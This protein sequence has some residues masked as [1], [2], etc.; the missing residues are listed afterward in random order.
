MEDSDKPPAFITEEAYRQKLDF[1][2]MFDRFKHVYPDAVC[3]HAMYDGMFIEK[4]KQDAALEMLSKH[5]PGSEV[6]LELMSPMLP[7]DAR[8]S[9]S[10]FYPNKLPKFLYD[11]DVF[12]GSYLEI[13]GMS[14]CS[15]E[16]YDELKSLPP[17]DKA[18]LKQDFRMEAEK[19]L[20]A[21]WKAA[22]VRVKQDQLAKSWSEYHVAA[23]GEIYLVVPERVKEFMKANCIRPSRECDR[24]GETVLDEKAAEILREQI[25]RKT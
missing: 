1:Q 4:E 23:R 21:E 15:P 6:T 16:L 10:I 8:D 22:F 9:A 11:C 20:G 14:M 19:E 17:N 13:I 18:L 3:T 7:S 25:D 12:P 24:Y 5:F 2:G